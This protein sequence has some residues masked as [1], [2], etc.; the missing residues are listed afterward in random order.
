MVTKPFTDVI[1]AACRFC[2]EFELQLNKPDYNFLTFR[3]GENMLA[4]E[5]QELGD[6]IMLAQDAPEGS[7]R[8][9]HYDAEIVDGAMDVA[10][11]ALLQGYIT[12]RKRGCSHLQ[13]VI[14]TRT[15]FLGVCET[16]LAKTPPTKAGE[17]ITKPEG[18]QAPRIIDLLRDNGNGFMSE[19]QAA[20]I[21][22]Q[23][24]EAAGAVLPA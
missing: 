13:A 12:F 16:N 2:D 21:A 4:E 9:L 6:A 5:V 23:N 10:F 7:P 15:A 24:K 3:M 22:A 8:Q 17:K 11:I 1:D 18:W 14:K 20:E 19:K